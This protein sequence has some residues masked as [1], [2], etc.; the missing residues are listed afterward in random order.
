MDPV[1][2]FG[3]IEAPLRKFRRFAM[4]VERKNQLKI[5]IC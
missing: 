3:S 1:T 2:G 4:F 5:G